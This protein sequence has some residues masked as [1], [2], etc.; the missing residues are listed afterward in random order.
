MSEK[1]AKTLATWERVPNPKSGELEWVVEV[2]TDGF[3]HLCEHLNAEKGEPWSTWL[4]EPL[5]E[6]I[7]TTRVKTWLS[8]ELLDEFFA[9]LRADCLIAC[10]E[11]RALSYFMQ[12]VNRPQ[13]RWQQRWVLVL[14]SGA[15]LVLNQNQS[16][17]RLMVVTCYFLDDVFN[18]RNAREAT[19]I[20]T[21]TVARR[22]C[23][24]RTQQLRSS[25]DDVL[26]EQA[27]G[28]E[29][30]TQFAFYKHEDWGFADDGTLDPSSIA[31]YG[32]AA[33]AFPSSCNKN[34]RRTE[35]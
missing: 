32:R 29:K 30:H 7:R 20:A 15:I 24:Q 23:D 14:P 5:I 28:A 11:P 2:K 10:S 31:A 17:V 4:P 18:A 19:A 6:A 1:A 21:E 13:E 27:S 22:Y 25:R 12:K 35:S 33:V 26:V 3:G 34:Y 16:Q 8:Q 9:A